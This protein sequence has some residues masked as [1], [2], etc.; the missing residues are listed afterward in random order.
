MFNCP[1]VLALSLLQS[2]SQDSCCHPSMT[3]HVQGRKGAV[4][5]TVSLFVSNENC[6][7]KLRLL[8]LPSHWPELH[9]VVFLNQFLARGMRLW[10]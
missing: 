4:S 5:S 9:E 3:C 10:V 8:F 7:L 6:P 2:W 1:T